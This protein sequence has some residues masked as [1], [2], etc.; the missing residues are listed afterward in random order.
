MDSLVIIFAVMAALI[1]VGSG[2]W[3][4]AVLVSVISATRAKTVLRTPYGEDGKNPR[5]DRDKDTAAEA[6]KRTTR[7]D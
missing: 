2:V 1:V 5:S 3:V 4:A 6:E 7:P